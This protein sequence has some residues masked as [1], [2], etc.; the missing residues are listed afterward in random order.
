MQLALDW[1]SLNFQV[2]FAVEI[3]YTHEVVYKI[4][5]YGQKIKVIDVKAYRKYTNELYYPH[6]LPVPLL[7]PRYPYMIYFFEEPTTLPDQEFYVDPSK[8]GVHHL[9]TT[10]TTTTTTEGPEVTT[11]SIDEYSSDSGNSSESEFSEIAR[12]NEDDQDEFEPKNNRLRVTN[13]NRPLVAMLKR[14]LNNVLRTNW[15]I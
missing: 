5:A 11:E 4:S 6:G 2:D 15:T 7:E 1:I 8:F 9:V 14:I 10:T 3:Y 13:V 12:I